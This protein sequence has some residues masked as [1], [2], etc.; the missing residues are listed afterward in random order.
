MT[1]LSRSVVFVDTN[2][3]HE[4][5]GVLKSFKEISELD[6]DDQNI[7]HKNLLERYEHR[8]H[9]LNNI[10]LAEFAANY[11]ATYVKAKNDDVLPPATVP[12]ESMSAS[13]T[14]TDGFGRMSKRKREAVIRFRRYNKE[15]EPSNYY[16]AKLML[17]YPW[18]NE[19]Y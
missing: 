8:P 16:R 19:K 17:Y 18:H 15:K 1:Q 11:S 3:S 10:C 4:R 5:V 6:G 14:L 2:P 7:F 12:S 13:I 9:S